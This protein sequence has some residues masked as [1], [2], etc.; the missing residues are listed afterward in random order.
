VNYNRLQ[1]CADHLNSR[2]LHCDLSAQCFIT[3]RLLQPWLESIK[4]LVD[5]Q[6]P[7]YHPVSMKVDRVDLGRI[8]DCFAFLVFHC[9]VGCNVLDYEIDV[10]DVAVP[11]FQLLKCGWPKLLEKVVFVD[12]DDLAMGKAFDSRL[13]DLDVFENF[14]MAEIM[15]RFQV[16]DVVLEN[17]GLSLDLP[18]L[19]VFGIFQ[20]G[21]VFYNS[22][23][24]SFAFFNN[25]EGF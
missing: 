1:L 18:T 23:L 10:N 22:F 12:V 17:F 7:G 24:D 13:A 14:F 15:S 9:D 5:C 2:Q 4:L 20:V 3:L 21:L 19:G 11:L 6:I 25:V 8:K 16:P